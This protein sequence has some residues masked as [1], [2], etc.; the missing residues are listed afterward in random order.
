M[1]VIFGIGAFQAFVFSLLL[2]TKNN[3]KTSDKFLAGFFFIVALYFFNIC[4]SAFELW[5]E[6]PDIIFIITLVVLT[7][8]PLLYFYVLSL[9][10]K[11]IS[12][13]QLI[14]HS[15]PII[16]IYLIILPFIFHSKDE[17]T[18]YFTDKFINLPLNVSL[19]LFIQ[20]LSAPIYFI[21]I[22]VI[23]KK[24]KKDLKDTY[25]SIEKNNLDWMHKLLIGAITFWMMDCL[26]IYAL[27][28]TNLYYPYI[29]SFYIKILFM[30]FIILIGYYGIKQGGV[31]VL[32]SFQQLEESDILSKESTRSHS[33]KIAEENVKAFVAHIR[34]EK[35]NSEI[36]I[37]DIAMNLKIPSYVLSQILN[38][39]VNRDT[40]NGNDEKVK[41]IPDIE[42]GK[43]VGILLEYMKK[44]KVYLNSE[45]RIQDIAIKLNIS[46]HILSHILNVTLNQNFFDFVNTYRIEEAKT[47]LL[48]TQYNNLTVLAIAYD[49]G[50]NSKAT[51]NRLFKQY[52]GTTPTQY[53]NSNTL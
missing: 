12:K 9:I 15:I 4:S 41:L 52:T 30:G 28:Y 29:V 44:E 34:D 1:A 2:L 16:G 43:H 46:V 45:L 10:G 37:Q 14:A 21:W 48:D 18:L 35:V 13:K 32:T 19:G 40:N 3:R 25:S 51:F 22:I 50:F 42:V 17:K 47:R 7:I 36:C 6:F 11:K 27:N 53:K 33:D 38:V 26:N 5:R 31:F 39:K 20:Y 49:C 24:Y 8:G 23:L